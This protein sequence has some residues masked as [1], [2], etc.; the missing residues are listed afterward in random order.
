MK[1]VIDNLTTR[2]KNTSVGKSI[3]AYI[4]G[5]KQMYETMKYIKTTGLTRTEVTE[6]VE[7][8]KWVDGNGYSQTDVEKHVYIYEQLADALRKYE[9]SEID[10]KVDAFE[11]YEEVIRALENAN[12]TRV[13]E[14]E[15]LLEWTDLVDYMNHNGLDQREAK[16]ACMF[17]E[18]MTGIFDETDGDD[19]CQRAEQLIE[20][21]TVIDMC[22]DLQLDEEGIIELIAKA[23]LVDEIA[24]VEDVLDEALTFAES[25]TRSVSE[26]KSAFEVLNLKK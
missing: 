10:E 15:E 25:L 24:P 4:Y 18:N 20:Y 23:K 7:M 5:T 26:A 17:Y 12:I 11:E 2:I 3:R 8:F 19:M 13:D 14:V 6:A 1:N 16:S 21:E 9:P 22:E